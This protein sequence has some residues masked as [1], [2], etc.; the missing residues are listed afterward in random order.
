MHI[1]SAHKNCV[2]QI[3]CISFFRIEFLILLHV[4]HVDYDLLCDT[5]V[6][7]FKYLIFELF[8]KKEILV[9][10]LEKIF[11]KSK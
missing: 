2:V 11:R 5:A 3:S 9:T 8:M 7:C 10:A 4:V 1:L 6:H